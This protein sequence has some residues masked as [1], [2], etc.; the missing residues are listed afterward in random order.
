MPFKKL[1]TFAAAA[2]LVSGVAFAQSAKITDPQIAHVAYTAGN[3]DIKAAELA[4]KKS[5]DSDVRTF[6]E[7]MVKDHKAVNQQALALLKK[8]KVTPEDNATSQS[9][10]AD[11]KE[12][13]A[14]LSKLNGAEF[15]KAYIQNEV[16]YHVT[17]NGALDTTL[18]PSTTNSEL[19][20]LLITGLK[21]FQGHQQHAEDLAQKIQSKHARL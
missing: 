8:L 13:Y 5:K 17:V 3:I 19:K 4:L 18:I 2:F 7:S 14:M 11:A 1:C 15:D 10:S 9:L 16:T 20:E 21:I 6:A 12:K